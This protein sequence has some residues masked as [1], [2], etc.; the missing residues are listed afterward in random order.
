MKTI[1]YNEMLVHTALCSHPNPKQ[2]LVLEDRID[3]NI[4]DELNK[5]KDI[6]ISFTK[7]LAEIED[8]SFDIILIDEDAGNDY[9]EES[10]RVLKDDGLAV[11]NSYNWL[12]DL[13]LLEK[14]LKQYS[15]LYWITI[16]FRFDIMDNSFIFASKKY[17]PTADLNLQRADLIDNLK[18]YTADVHNASFVLP[19]YID[20]LLKNVLKK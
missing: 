14:D 3:R 7:D 1:V 13:D 11:I 9:L 18:F 12:D 5:H 16:P 10:Y 8:K 17:H 15:K 2:V 4:E 6:E 19:K 20:D